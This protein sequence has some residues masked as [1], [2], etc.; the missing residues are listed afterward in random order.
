MFKDFIAAV[1]DCT[2][3][4]KEFG[5]VYNSIKNRYHPVVWFFMSLF[6]FKK[7]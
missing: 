4:M 3:S 6:F 1:Q 2:Q 7:I 5:V